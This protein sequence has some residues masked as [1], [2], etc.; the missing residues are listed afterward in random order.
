MTVTLPILRDWMTRYVMSIFLVLGVLGNLINVYM[1]TRKDSLRSSCSFYL[2]AA[3]AV[4]TL[5]VAWGIIPSLYILDR[6]DP[7]TYSFVYCK[8]RLYTI[9]TILMI[10][11]SLIVCACIDRYAL[12]S[13]STRLRSFCAPKVAVRIIIGHFCVWPLITVYITFIQE[14]VAIGAPCTARTV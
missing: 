12:C 13:Q 11:R 7:S 5:C 6:T 4:N 3:S 10:G 9:H 14:F 8:L 1:F 2:V